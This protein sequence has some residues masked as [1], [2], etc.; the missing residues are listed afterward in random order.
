M[1]LVGSKVGLFVEANP[2]FEKIVPSRWHALLY[3]DLGLIVQ[4]QEDVKWPLGAPL[5]V[6]KTPQ[7]KGGIDLNWTGFWVG[8]IEEKWQFFLGYYSLKLR[9]RLSLRQGSAGE[10]KE[11]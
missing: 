9:C 5:F 10:A 6:T 4:R 1:G 11:A 7:L 8:D 3:Q 2:Y